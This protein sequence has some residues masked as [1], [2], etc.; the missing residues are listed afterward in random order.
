MR[1]FTNPQRRCKKCN[2]RE[3]TTL[4]YNGTSEVNLRKKTDGTYEC[5]DEQECNRNIAAEKTDVKI[6]IDKD[7]NIRS[8]SLS[9]DGEKIMSISK[10]EEEEE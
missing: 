3:V 10:K 2:G 1:E 7:G 9:Y 4:F 5:K 6:G 8:T